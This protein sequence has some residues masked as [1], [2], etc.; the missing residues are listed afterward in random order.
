MIKSLK[1]K[2]ILYIA[3]GA[4][5]LF[6]VYFFQDYL[7]FYSLIFEF[8]PPERLGYGIAFTEVDTLPFVVNKAGRY[9]LNDL[10]FHCH[11]L[12]HFYRSVN[13]PALHFT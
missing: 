1:L 12:R 8:S 13:M 6:L 11:Y 4:T 10:F 7:D 3:G 2:S 9:L 5:G